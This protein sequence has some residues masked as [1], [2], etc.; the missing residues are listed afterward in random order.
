MEEGSVIR[1][2]SAETWRVTGILSEQPLYSNRGNNGVFVLNGAKAKKAAIGKK[3][4]NTADSITAAVAKRRSQPE[5][6]AWQALQLNGKRK[7][8]AVI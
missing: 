3:S 1:T 4:R 5:N 2:M 8:G 6:S 7:T